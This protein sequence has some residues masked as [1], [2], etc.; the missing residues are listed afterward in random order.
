MYVVLDKNNYLDKLQTISDDNRKFQPI[1]LKPTAK[2]K[3]DLNKIIKKI[4]S[5]TVPSTTV[6]CKV[7]RLDTGDYEPGYMYGKVKTH[8]NSYPLRLIISQLLTLIY[9]CVC[10]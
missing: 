6:E 7:F 5:A 10:V 4:N 3:T 2:L 8:K 1:T 9:F